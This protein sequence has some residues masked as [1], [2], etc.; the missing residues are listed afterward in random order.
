MSILQKTLR[1]AG[2]PQGWLGRSIVRGMN[3]GHYSLT[4]WGLRLVDIAREDPDEGW[5][6]MSARA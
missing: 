3:S 5:F 6:A 2:R 1:Q 4:S